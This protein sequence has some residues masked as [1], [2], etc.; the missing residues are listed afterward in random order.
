MRYRLVTCFFFIIIIFFFFFFF[1]FFSAGHDRTTFGDSDFNHFDDLDDFDSR[2]G[3]KG[4]K[5]KEEDDDDDSFDILGNLDDGALD[6]LMKETL[7]DDFPF[8]RHLVP[9]PRR[10]PVRPRFLARAGWLV[11]LSFSRARNGAHANRT[12]LQRG[13]VALH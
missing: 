6:I 5:R 2:S 10:Q 13:A 11:C 4:G 7:S 9:G 1:F 8:P 3:T 12:R